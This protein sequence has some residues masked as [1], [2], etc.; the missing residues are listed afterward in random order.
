LRPASCSKRSTASTEKAG[1]GAGRGASEVG[2]FDLFTIKH[3]FV[4]VLDAEFDLRIRDDRFAFTALHQNSADIEHLFGLIDRL[5]GAEMSGVICQQDLKRMVDAVGQYVVAD[6]LRDIVIEEL[7]S[8]VSIGDR[9]NR[10]AELVARCWVANLRL[11]GVVGGG[12]K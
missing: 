1:L 10:K 3:R 2:S 8:L 7:P 4:F 11:F 9:A 6:V 12:E 5:I